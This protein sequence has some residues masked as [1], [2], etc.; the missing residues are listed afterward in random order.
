MLPPTGLQTRRLPE[1]RAR[2]SDE[3]GLADLPRSGTRADYPRGRSHHRFLRVTNRKSA[4]DN[5]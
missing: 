5:Y 1:L 3:S 4:F 2:R